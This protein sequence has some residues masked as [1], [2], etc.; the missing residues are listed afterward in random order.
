MKKEEINQRLIGHSAIL[1][2]AH[3]AEIPTEVAHISYLDFAEIAE[4]KLILKTF[5]KKIAVEKY[6]VSAKVPRQMFLDVKKNHNISVDAMIDNVLV[7]E[8]EQ[9]L[10][11]QIKKKINLFAEKNY[12][13]TYN[14][15]DKIKKL[16]N[17]KYV[18]KIKINN[19]EDLTRKILV[20]SNKILQYGRRGSANYVLC[21]AQTGALLQNSSD[22]V[23]MMSETNIDKNHSMP[24]AVGMFAGM[25]FYVDPMMNF[26]DNTIYV[27][28]KSFRE[29][30]G[31][32]LA[33][34]KEGTE[35][36][37]TAGTENPEG[38][39]TR[40]LIIKCAVAEIG[41]HPEVNYRKFVY[42]SKK[43]SI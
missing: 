27:C 6:T 36:V 9:A 31:I 23:M 8:A 33:F 14:F 7:Q 22:A 35:T 4:D 40:S 5:A 18:K 19:I 32:I 41:E 13:E 20:E 29:E 37:I 16:F 24:Y 34:H 21:S 1:D 25:K 10:F 17:K 28:K 2:F 39:Q 42:K 38:E 30:P 43:L 15:W 11:K 3:I 26:N 12:K